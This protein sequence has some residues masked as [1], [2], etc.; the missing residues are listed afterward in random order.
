MTFGGGEMTRGETTGYRIEAKFGAKGTKKFMET[1]LAISDSYYYHLW[2]CGST[3]QVILK[4]TFL[5][6]LSHQN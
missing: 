3:L 4:E 1:T 2:N 6:F 5:L